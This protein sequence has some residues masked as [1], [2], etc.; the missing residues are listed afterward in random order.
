MSM[1]RLRTFTFDSQHAWQRGDF[2]IFVHRLQQEET[3]SHEH[4][5]HEIVYIESGTAD[6]LTATGTQKLHPGDVIILKPRIWHQY[7]RTQS[8]TIINCL[9]DGAV[10]RHYGAMLRLGERVF[11]LFRQRT[12][13]PRQTPPTVLHAHPASRPHLLSTLETMMSELHDQ[14]ADWQAVVTVRLL[15]FLVTIARLGLDPRDQPPPAMT[16]RAMEAVVEAAD[17]L[18]THFTETIML[19]DLAR[20]LHLSPAYLSR[21]FKKRMG[22]GIVRYLHHL[23]TEE[24]CRCLRGTS[25]S[26]S[27]IAGRVGYDEIAYFSRC[28]RREVGV[29][30]HAYRLAYKSK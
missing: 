11:Q 12:P 3:V 9:F 20:H 21:T 13:N 5:F 1:G 19:D 30:P 8:F 22:M 26:I 14:S 2:H 6:H 23:R 25:E 27:N 18:E 29:S 15:D 10:L 4:V 17:Y 28:F 24:A 7:L 16:N